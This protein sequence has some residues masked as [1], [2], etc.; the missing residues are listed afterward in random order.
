MKN[1]QYNIKQEQQ[2]TTIKYNNYYLK[3]QTHVMIAAI[4][5]ETS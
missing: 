2:I 1:P 5:H 4:N 3:E